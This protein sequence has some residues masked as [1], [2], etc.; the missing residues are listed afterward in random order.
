MNCRFCGE[1]HYLNTIMVF[2]HRTKKDLPWRECCVCGFISQLPYNTDEEQQ[3]L[4]GE[5]DILDPEFRAWH[6]WDTLLQSVEYNAEIMDNEADRKAY[7]QRRYLEVAAFSGYLMDHMKRRGW[8]VRGQELTKHGCEEAAKHGL[9]VEQSCVFQW[10]PK[11]EFDV[12][13]C[14]EFL[15]HVWDF[16]GLM[17]RMFSWQAKGGVLWIQTPVTDGGERRK[18]AFQADHCSLFN[19][20]NIETLLLEV[21]YEP[22]L[23]ENRQGCGIIKALKRTCPA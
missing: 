5:F 3:K 16:R 19:L 10:D 13:S 20:K 4:Y 21:G 15:E 7:P 23:L 8:N 12:I 14:R 18:L 2:D 17:R 9:H 1:G 22:Q 11:A 6:T